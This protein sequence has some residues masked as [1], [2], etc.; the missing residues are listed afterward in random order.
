MKISELPARTPRTCGFVRVAVESILFVRAQ[1]A[2]AEPNSEKI[3]A[4][5]TDPEPDAPGHF[6]IEAIFG[7]WLAGDLGLDGF[8]AVEHRED[9]ARNRPFAVD[10]QREEADLAGIGSRDVG[11]IERRILIADQKKPVEGAN[12]WSMDTLVSRSFK[13][14]ELGFLTPVVVP[15]VV[16]VERSN[17]LNRAEVDAQGCHL[18]LADSNGFL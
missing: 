3:G 18:D 4:V 16:R 12:W 17:E 6:T 10:G 2:F 1:L 9:L 13:I 14:S 5:E 7:D 11:A 15:I 8:A